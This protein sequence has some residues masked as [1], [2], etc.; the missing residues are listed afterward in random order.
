M[1]PRQE[2]RQMNVHEDPAVNERL[3]DKDRIRNIE[4]DIIHQRDALYALVAQNEKYTEYIDGKIQEKKDSHEFWT[5]VRKKLAV[6]GI[7][8]TILIVFT[9]II[10]AAKQWILTH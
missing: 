10:Y 7:W 1:T 5:S 8:G 3:D 4:G 9:V 2:L 6:S